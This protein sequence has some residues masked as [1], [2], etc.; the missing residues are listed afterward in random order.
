MPDAGKKR[1]HDLT[2]IKRSARDH[3]RNNAPTGSK[4]LYAWD[5]ACIDYRLWSQLKHTAGIYFITREKS[6]SIA[7]VCGDNLLNKIR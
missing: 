3:L 7:T 6:N 5:K 4:I 1:T 2:I